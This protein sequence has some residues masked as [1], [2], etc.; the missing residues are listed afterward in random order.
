MSSPRI[1]ESIESLARATAA[2]PAVVR[3]AHCGE[4]RP[5]PRTLYCVQQTVTGPAAVAPPVAA[6]PDGAHAPPSVGSAWARLIDCQAGW[7]GR[8][9]QPSEVALTGTRPTMLVAAQPAVGAVE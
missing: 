2:Y 5:T 6:P 1:P 4:M 3:V 9:A 8:G 7:S